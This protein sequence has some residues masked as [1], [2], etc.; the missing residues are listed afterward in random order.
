MDLLE[1]SLTI[2]EDRIARAAQRCNRLPGEVELI[3]ISKGQPVEKIREVVDAGK[4][5]FGE[6]RL[7]EAAPKIALLPSRL[8]WHYIGHLQTNKIRKTL[9]LFEL[10]HSVDHLELAQEIDRIATEVGLFPRVLLEVN[11]SGEST[12][13]GFS[14][15]V[16]KNSFEKLLRLPRLQVEGLMTMAPLSCDPEASRPY[17][18][19]LRKL[20]DALAANAGIPLPTLSMGMSSDFE[21]AIEEGATMVRVGSAIFK[22]KNVVDL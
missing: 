19:R 22:K 12:K 8:R 3:V 2:V 15:E 5:L 10:I 11:V 21:V 14:P 9:P 16:L 20:R 7:Q 17:F 6:S 1:N 13:Y 18:E 4:T